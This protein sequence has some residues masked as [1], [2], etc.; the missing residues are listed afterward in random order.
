MAHTK[1]GRETH[2]TT[3][4]NGQDA[5]RGWS[6]EHFISRRFST[7]RY[8]WDEDDGEEDAFAGCIWRGMT[9]NS[10][11][12]TVFHDRWKTYKVSTLYV[13]FVILCIRANPPRRLF[14]SAPPVARRLFKGGVYSRVA[15]IRGNTVYI[16]VYF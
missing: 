9:T 5:I 10:R 16:R 11:T 7:K 14:H 8:T 4:H 12:Q 15:S 2:K 6:T 1:F 3:T 13:R